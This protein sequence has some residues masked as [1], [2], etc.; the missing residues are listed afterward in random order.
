MK[1]QWR[2]IPKGSDYKGKRVTQEAWF[3]VMPAAG[4][5]IVGTIIRNPDDSWLIGLLAPDGKRRTLVRP[6]S[7]SVAQA[8]ELWEFEYKESMAAKGQFERITINAQRDKA[9]KRRT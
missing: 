3:S 6:S 5:L 1:V 9:V 4:D 7:L 8:Q 2:H